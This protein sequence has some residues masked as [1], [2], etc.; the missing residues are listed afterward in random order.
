MDLTSQ[1]SHFLLRGCPFSRRHCWPGKFLVGKEFFSR[2]GLPATLRYRPDHVPVKDFEFEVV[3]GPGIGIYT[4]SLP[5]SIFHHVF[6]SVPGGRI[7]SNDVSAALSAA[8]FGQ[9]W[10][11]PRLITLPIVLPPSPSY[12][13]YVRPNVYCHGAL[14]FHRNIKPENSI[15]N[16]GWVSHWDD[17][18]RGHKVAVK[19]SDFG[20]PVCQWKHYVHDVQPCSYVIQNGM[21]LRSRSF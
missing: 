19:L 4:G 17:C 13:S 10:P 14:V 18:I 21:L 6:H 15:V 16:D 8:S 11:L 5:F 20:L 7:E 3:Q 12:R 2:A 9:F 1:S